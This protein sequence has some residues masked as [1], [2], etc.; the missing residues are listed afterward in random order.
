MPKLDRGS[1][2]A[3]LT[4]I[5][6]LAAQVLVHRLVSLKLLNN[7]AFLVIS[8]TMLGFG[9]SGVVLS[10]LLPRFERAPGDW[11][12]PSSGL[13]GATLVGA[14]SLLLRADIVM[15]QRDTRPDF[16]LVFLQSIPYALIFA[17]PFSFGGLVLGALLSSREYPTR[18][19]YFFDLMGSAAGAFLI[20]PVIGGIGVERAV[21]AVALLQM[22]G[23]AV[24]MPPRGKHAR[25][26][27]AA[28]GA[29]VLF[30]AV[31]TGKVFELRATGT[32]TYSPT[33]G[34]DKSARLMHTR[35]DPLGRAELWSIGGAPRVF[36]LQSIFG[37]DP[38]YR[39]RFHRVL[40][41]N[42]WAYTYAPHI[43]APVESIKGIERTLYAASYI[44]SSVTEPNVTV[45]GVGG[46]SD[47]IAALH[48]RA[49]HVNGVEANGAT[50]DI[51][52]R[53]DREYFAGWAGDPRVNL[54]H[55]EGRHFLA[56][57]TDRFD[58][59]QLSGVDTYAGTPGAAHVFTENYLYTQEAFDLYLSR[60][61]DAGVFNVVRVDWPPPRETLRATATAVRALR[62]AGAER[63][64]RHVVVLGSADSLLLALIVKKTPFT[65]AELDK[66]AATVES[67]AM[68][69]VVASPRTNA[70]RQNIYQ[71]FLSL[72]DADNEATFLAQSPSNVMPVDDD[73]PFF[74][75]YSYWWHVFPRDPA[76]WALV[77]A[78][79]YSVMLL[80]VVVGVTAMACI[81]F[82]L[83]RLR[84]HGA[85][86]APT[87]RFAVYFAALGLGYMAAEM[88]LLQ[89]FGL[90]LG[91]PS[92]ALSVVL[93]GLLFATG[94]GALMAER[95]VTRLG[96]VRFVS[97]LFSA[98]VFLEVLVIFPRL[99]ALMPASFAV[100]CAATLILVFPVGLCLGVF[101]PSGIE[102][103]KARSAS[104][105]VPWAWGVNGIFSVLGPVLAIA[106]SIT[107]GISALMLLAVPIYLVAGWVF[108]RE[109]A[110]DSSGTSEVGSPEATTQS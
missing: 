2:L 75:R 43:D 74:F 40:T 24:L 30:A 81:W 1:L 46:G 42:N 83:G 37:D 17:V 32:F 5:S 58:V 95:I 99:P 29:V 13:F 66:I 55:D 4:A 20:L 38:E 86:A 11:L 65:D 51:I 90:L 78:M 10:R 107:F 69:R 70:K 49:R 67:N 35:W 31:F 53:A 14:S 96:G 64:S 16:V 97:Y 19:V 26:V 44:A 68:I 28:C 34:D 60:L 94:T 25:A 3:A 48:Y 45:I 61:T 21:V 108:P 89:Q 76:I 82:P 104:A 63:P 110:A 71:A 100:R 57:S 36:P 7:Y 8:L 84:K 85:T 105:L 77:P 73:Q 98:V 79:E 15:S 103:L 33:R 88:A 18:R 54:V 72:E 41:Q 91:H 12:T 59:I 80:F 47:V 9:L 50:L 56:T 23:T 109:A 27:T 101:L 93:A 22:V 106:L 52:R 62:R 6:M 92:Y 39:A 102:A 87:G